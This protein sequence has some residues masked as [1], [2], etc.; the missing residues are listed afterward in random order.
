LNYGDLLIVEKRVAGL[1]A[2]YFVAKLI[3]FSELCES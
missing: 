1:L 3:I 2:C